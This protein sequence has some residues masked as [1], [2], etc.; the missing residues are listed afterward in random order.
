[1][2]ETI[3]LYEL[4][5]LDELEAAREQGARKSTFTPSLFPVDSRAFASVGGKLMQA[6][7]INAMIDS[8]W[9]TSRT[10]IPKLKKN[11][12]DRG[13]HKARWV[14]KNRI[15]ETREAR[16]WLRKSGRNLWDGCFQS[17]YQ[18]VLDWLEEKWK[19]V[20]KD[21]TKESALRKILFDCLEVDV[22]KD[23]QEREVPEL[24]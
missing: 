5:T 3:E 24:E 20:D 11:K 9:S 18:P 1:M 14:A 12:G 8:A 7:I 13:N 16:R 17:Q 6:V 10:R 19:E 21:M 15:K 2:E 23:Y 4:Y 22:E